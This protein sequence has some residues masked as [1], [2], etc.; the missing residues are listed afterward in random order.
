MVEEMGRAWW[1]R[2]RVGGAGEFRDAIASTTST[3]SRTNGRSS[4]SEIDIMQCG[5]DRKMNRQQESPKNRFQTV[6]A[7]E[8]ENHSNPNVESRMIL[9]SLSS[10]PATHSGTPRM[11]A[12]TNTRQRQR[13]RQ[14]TATCWRVIL[15]SPT[16]DK[17]HCSIPYV[18]PR[19]VA[20]ISRED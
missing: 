15:L 17:S 6:T 1:M 9:S 2:G 8:A 18:S 7:T 20:D 13:Q 10:S 11:L 4:G 3:A 5:R 16:S 12:E 14:T 19:C